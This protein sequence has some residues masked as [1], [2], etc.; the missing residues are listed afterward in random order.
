MLMG[1][2]ATLALVLGVLGAY[3]ILAESARQ[4]RRDAA[5][6]LALGAPRLALLRQ[7]VSNAMRLAA[8]G[9]A[10]GMIA[11]LVVR[12]S[13]PQSSTETGMS[14]V[15]AWLDGPLV[16][17]VLVSLASVLPMLRVLSVV[18]LT[19]LREQ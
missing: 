3:A 15:R 18:P 13:L 19:T 12:S 10:A 16:I 6:R 4:Q 7:M 5:V 14:N 8:A 1:V 11:A 17:F 9:A 2:A